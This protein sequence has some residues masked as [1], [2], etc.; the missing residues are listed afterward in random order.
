MA[1]KLAAVIALA[2]S[3]PVIAS[4]SVASSTIPLTVAEASPVCDTIVASQLSGVASSAM[5]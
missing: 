5:K 4:A 2:V 3:L 1:A